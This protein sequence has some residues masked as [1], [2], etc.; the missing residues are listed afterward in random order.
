MVHHFAFFTKGIGPNLFLVNT[1]GL[2]LA[3]TYTYSERKEFFTS[4]S[5]DLNCV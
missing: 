3:S 1:L 5:T 2:P 4:Y